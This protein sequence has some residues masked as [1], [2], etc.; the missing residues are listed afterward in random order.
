MA[1]PSRAVDVQMPLGLL[2]LV[3]G[4][5]NLY[6]G[7]SLSRGR[8]VPA[9]VAQDRVLTLVFTDDWLPPELRGSRT[10]EA[11]IRVVVGAGFALGGAVCAVQALANAFG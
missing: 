3:L 8:G 4:L 1:L 6:V 7:W 10:F 5:P 9:L 11:G 2:L